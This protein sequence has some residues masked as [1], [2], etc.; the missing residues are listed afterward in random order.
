MQARMHQGIALDKLRQEPVGRGRLPQKRTWGATPSF[1][2]EIFQISPFRSSPD[3]VIFALW[4]FLTQPRKRY[5][6]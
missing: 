3:K 5:Q 2:C 6:P 1:I 4:E